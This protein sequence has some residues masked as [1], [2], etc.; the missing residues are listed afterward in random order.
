M[1]K[2]PAYMGL[3]EDF[4]EI[5]GMKIIEKEAYTDRIGEYADVRDRYDAHVFACAE[6]AKCDCV[7][8]GDRDIL[9]Y[10][11][12]KIRAVNAAEFLRYVKE[13]V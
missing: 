4:V 5:S 7:I 13:K 3:F 8:S 12:S 1:K 6:Y 2:F 11:K 10:K 9:S